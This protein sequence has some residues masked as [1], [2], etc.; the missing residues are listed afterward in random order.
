[1]IAEFLN[2]GVV[3]DQLADL[4]HFVASEV[5]RG[6]A[7][8]LALADQQQLLAELDA[9]ERRERSQSSGQPGH[10]ATGSAR[11]P[12]GAALDDFSYF[13]RDPILSLLQSALDEYYA[14]PE[15]AHEVVTTPANGARQGPADVVVTDRSLGRRLPPGP[16]DGRPRVFDKFSITDIR[17]IRSKLAEGI[18]LLRGKHAFNET[19]AAPVTIADRARFVLAG[20]WATG[21]P[22]AQKVAAQMRRAIDDAQQDGVPVHVAH[23]GDVYYSG[24]GHE[25]LRRFLPYWP[26][27]LD[28]ADRIGSW[29]L[30]GNHDMYAGGHAYYNVGL[31]D[32][33]FAR[34]QRSSFFSLVNAHWTILG[35][36]TAWE[37]HALKD[38][39]A[40][41]L[42]QELKAAG[43]R[44]TVLLSH[45]QLFSAY[46]PPEPELAA[47]VAPILARTP[48]TA[49]FW[50]HEHRCMVYNA[51]EHVSFARC[52]GHA[53]VPVYMW[54]DEP[55]AYPSP[56]KYEYR[57]FI[58]NGLERWALFGFAVLDFDG[59]ALR[60][61]YVDENGDTHYTETI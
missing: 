31:A 44:K 18:R 34:Q 40:D 6:E 27:R 8:D 12:G 24:W 37:D 39:Q 4:R 10:D 56:G 57:K 28:E 3:L 42:A 15:H 50:G 32:P 7:S 60:V 61:R 47:R 1:M 11:G 16:G 36:D 13:S 23:L 41:W 58:R 29:C 53:G 51:H 52:I 20:D 21:L 59:P 35:L 30:N 19:P 46:E 17:W 55:D 48:V 45:H 25:Y 26:V 49:W 54:H 5:A 14:Q 43:A 33:R 38:P 2:R 9:A 22:R